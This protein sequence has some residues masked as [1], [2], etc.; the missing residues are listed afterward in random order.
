MVRRGLMGVLAV[1]LLS[2]TTV[3]FTVGVQAAAAHSVPARYAHLTRAR[4]VDVHALPP[5]HQNLRASHSMLVHDRGVFN[6]AKAAPTASTVRIAGGT[7]P[8]RPQAAAAAG[9]GFALLSHDQQVALNTGYDFTPPDTQLAAGPTSLLEMVNVLGAIYSKSGTPI[10]SPFDLQQFFG[11]PPGFAFYDPRVIFDRSIG[12]WIASGA[13][14]NSDF[15][16]GEIYLAVST[17][18]DPA[19]PWNTYADDGAAD[20]TLATHACD[21]PKIGTSLDKIGLSCQVYDNATPANFLGELTFVFHKA[22][23]VSGASSPDFFERGPDPRIFSIAPAVAQSATTTLWMPYNNGQQPNGTTNFLGVFAVTG[24]PAAGTVTFTESQPAMTGTHIPPS[25]LQ[26]GNPAPPPLQTDDDRL[27]SA[28]WQGGVLWTAA[29]DSCTPTT[30][31]TGPSV[32]ACL[33]LVAV[34]TGDLSKPA[35][36]VEYAIPDAD[37][38]YPAIAPDAAGN[39]FVAFSES[40]VA[41]PASALGVVLSSGSNTFGPPTAIQAGTGDYVETAPVPPNGSRFGDYSAAAADPCIA[42]GVWLAA[43][44]SENATSGKNWATATVLVS[45]ARAAPPGPR[46]SDVACLGGAMISGA[47]AAS[48]GAGRVDVFA[49]GPNH[50]LVHTWTDGSW[51]PW[52]SLGGYLTADP[53]AVSWSHGDGTQRLDV[54]VRGG[55]NALWH[56]WWDGTSWSGWQSLGGALASG[57]DVSSWSNGRLDVFGIGAGRQLLHWWWDGTRWSGPQGLGGQFT[58]DPTAVSWAANRIDVFTRGVDRQLWHRWWNGIAWSGWEAQGGVL[59]GS[60]DVASWGSGRLDVFIQGIDQ[61]LW[62]KWWDG[63]G[64]S[65]WE[66]HGGFMGSDPTAVSA[67]TGQVDVFYRGPDGELM[68]TGYK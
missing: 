18:A 22:D 59:A 47:D 23:L 33:R 12:R 29:N 1:S 15:T 13:S 53:G 51:H 35:R 52:Q 40:S 30:T 19:D 56:R 50:E 41:D 3:T 9:S 39:L 43:E 60:P 64:C 28:V 55:D 38:Y 2:G 45:Q 24:D 16:S 66:P 32:R 17:S 46:W 68:S 10:G 62:H 57:P 44:Y 63:T 14:A 49:T 65:A 26:P 21:Q 27:I 67:T 8:R 37:V 42:G 4:V 11:V 20:A 54:F 7:A 58:A 36:S 31:P 25:A 34:T 48:W 5:A 6:R 61:G